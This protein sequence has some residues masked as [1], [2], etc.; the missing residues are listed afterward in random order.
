MIELLYD[1]TETN[2][3]KINQSILPQFPEATLDKIEVLPDWVKKFM[4]R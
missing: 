2:A 1:A 3:A 4:L